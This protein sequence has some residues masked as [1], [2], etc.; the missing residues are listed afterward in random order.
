VAE[1]L[2]LIA[3]ALAALGHLLFALAAG[4]SGGAVPRAFARV[5]FAL[6]CWSAA[7]FLDDL[8]DEVGLEVPWIVALAIPPLGLELAARVH[9]A[10]HRL[11]RL[12]GASWVLS[13]L[14]AAPL[15]WRGAGVV[16]AAAFVLYPSLA[17]ALGSLRWAFAT[18]GRSAHGFVLAASIAVA[19]S[20]VD[21][22]RTLHPFAELPRLAALAS[23]VLVAQL[24]SSVA[25]HRLFDLKPILGRAATLVVI[26]LGAAELLA[27]TLARVPT[28]WG[29]RLLVGL[30]LIAF[31]LL[32]RPLVRSLRSPRA[33]ALA[34][35]RRE[36]LRRLA[37]LDRLLARAATLEELERELVAAL[38]RDPEV[39]DARLEL[40]RRRRARAP[41][42]PG[43]LE[44]PLRT[45]SR[46]RGTLRLS[47]RE[48]A[49]VRPRAL[50]RA[51]RSLAARVA[52][53]ASALRLQEQRR[54]GERLAHLGAL[55]AALAHEIKNPLGAILGA[56]ELID[57]PPG[58][59]RWLDIL[60]EES[61]RLDRTVTDALALGR[62]PRLETRRVAPREV[63][64]GA[65]L[66]AQERAVRGRVE[67]TLRA[68]DEASRAVELDPDQLRHAL[69]N[70]VLNAISVQPEGGRVEL[71]VERRPGAVE[72]HVRDD[73]PGVAPDLRARVFEPFFSTRPSGSG[74]GL[75]VA[76]RVAAAHGGRLEI[77]A[78]DGGYRGAHFVLSIP[79]PDRGDGHGA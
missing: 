21:T 39:A 43:E 9:G 63:A 75:A 55:A 78:P 58:Q 24:G 48:P 72:F 77:G 18:R 53:A 52:L 51:L 26:A 47:L 56:L 57:P 11:E 61:Q 45:G 40:A 5:A 2:S 46:R 10:A 25:R 76:Q 67:L 34:R 64:E 22:L 16:P 32:Q 17:F 30:V 29:R 6:A 12:A 66:L 60:R 28:P 1:P 74:I 69:L 41:P 68:E 49:L 79:D 8:L 54:R 37:G 73:G 71:S 31:A 42:A 14:T 4:R 44:L 23:L 36:L 38:R 33:R 59:R 27:E 19:A 7:V 65:R 62:A 35:R 3:S 15:A 50:R 70:L 13:A 20:A